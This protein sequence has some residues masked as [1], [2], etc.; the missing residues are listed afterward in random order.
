MIQNL[1]NLKS[2][3]VSALTILDMGCSTCK[4]TILRARCKK[5]KIIAGLSK[6]INNISENLPYL[7]AVLVRFAGFIGD[8]DLL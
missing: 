7:S 5:Y 8:F 3:T 2:K 4:W 6:Q 1:K